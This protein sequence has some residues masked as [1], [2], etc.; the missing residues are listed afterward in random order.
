MEAQGCYLA[1]HALFLELERLLQ[2]AV[3]LP[4]YEKANLEDLLVA[5][6][7]HFEG[8]FRRWLIVFRKPTDALGMSFP[9]SIDALV[10]ISRDEDLGPSV[11]NRA[12]DC[13]IAPIQILVFVYEKM[14]GWTFHVEFARLLEST[15][16]LVH[17][18]GSKRVSDRLPDVPATRPET[19]D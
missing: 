6:L 17:E 1:A 10:V 3:V 11:R 12:D 8:E 15:F 9:K 19:W 16:Q 2:S 18:L 14:L 5:A 13:K 4:S 7:A